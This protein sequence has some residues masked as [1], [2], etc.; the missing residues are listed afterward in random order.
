MATEVC[1]NG[2]IKL[3]NMSDIVEAIHICIV[4]ILIEL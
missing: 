2:S 4:N 1:C 3:L